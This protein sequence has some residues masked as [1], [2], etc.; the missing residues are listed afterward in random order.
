MA[1]GL[2]RETDLL[3]KQE[4]PR[5]CRTL[6]QFSAITTRTA[7]GHAMKRDWN[8]DDPPPTES[9]GELERVPRLGSTST[10][11]EQIHLRMVMEKRAAEALRS[12]LERDGKRVYDHA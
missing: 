1:S 11:T 12:V 7:G 3:T 10:A 2:T 4:T 6:P 8:K 9:A 5:H